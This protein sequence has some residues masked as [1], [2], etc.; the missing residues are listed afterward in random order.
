MVAV[1]GFDAELALVL[2][3]ITLEEDGGAP[4]VVD[5]AVVVVVVAVVVVGVVRLSGVVAASAPDPLNVVLMLSGVTASATADAFAAATLSAALTDTAAAAAT[6][7]EDEVVVDAFIEPEICS[8]VSS[9]FAAFEFFFD[10][11]FFDGNGCLT[12]LPKGFSFIGFVDSVVVSM[13]NAFTLELST[14]VEA[15]VVVDVEGD[16]GGGVFV[17]DAEGSF[18]SNFS[19]ASSI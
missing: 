17:V 13:T 7:D 16:D 1:V 18:R 3:G 8:V 12:F 9:I 6:V 5:D 4:I 15:T 14:V 11:V 2:D 19:M 10:S